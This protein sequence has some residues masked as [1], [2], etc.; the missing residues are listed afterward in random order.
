MTRAH[1][2]SGLFSE[3]NQEE[4]YSVLLQLQPDAWR[5]SVCSV[6]LLDVLPA[7]FVFAVD[8]AL[9]HAACAVCFICFDVLT[10]IIPIID[11][12]TSFR[13]QPSPI[14]QLLRIM[15]NELAPHGPNV[16]FHWWNFCFHMD[17]AATLGE[18]A[19]HV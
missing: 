3:E 15:N 4:V 11:M 10:K 16:T 1:A 12:F 18:A 13:N 5:T 7:T 9:F 6:S 2:L 19:L 14:P 17:M 8:F